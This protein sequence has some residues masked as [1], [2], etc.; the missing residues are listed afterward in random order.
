MR[1]PMVMK[2]DQIY[3]KLIF[4]KIFTCLA[5]NNSGLENPELKTSLKLSGC[6]RFKAQLCIF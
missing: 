5:P 4:L 6:K 3:E 1:N 2:P